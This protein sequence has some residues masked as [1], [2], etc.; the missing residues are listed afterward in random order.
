VQN[1]EVLP[2]EIENVNL[3]PLKK[4]KLLKRHVFFSKAAQKS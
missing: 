4:L 1:I 2:R 3:L